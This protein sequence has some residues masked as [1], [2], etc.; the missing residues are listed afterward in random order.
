MEAKAKKEAEKAT[1]DEEVKK[2]QE[3][4][5]EAWMLEQLKK[6]YG[7]DFGEDIDQDFS[8]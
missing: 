4:E 8:E 6:Q 1:E 7:E 5:D 3:Q 2:I